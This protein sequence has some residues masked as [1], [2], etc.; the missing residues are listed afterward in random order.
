[1]AEKCCMIWC[2]RPEPHEAH[3]PTTAEQIITRIVYCDTDWPRGFDERSALNA[4]QLTAQRIIADLDRHRTISTPEQLDA[5]PFLAVIREVFRDSPS[6]VNYGGVYERRTSGWECI[7]GV[8][9]DSSNNGTPRL[10]CRVLYAAA[11]S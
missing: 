7:A 6:G 5:L 11:G 9:K 2:E 1:M 10:P 4:S 3:E 8:Y